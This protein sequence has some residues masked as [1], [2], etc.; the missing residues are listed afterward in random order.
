MGDK[1]GQ[2]MQSSP[3]SSPPPI[4]PPAQGH[5]AQP[6]AQSCSNQLRQAGKIRLQGRLRVSGVQAAQLQ[7]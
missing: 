4:L 7:Q 2:S 1:Q 6:G 3:C 5:T